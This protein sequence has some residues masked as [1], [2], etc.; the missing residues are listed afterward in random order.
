MA[1]RSHRSGV[2]SVTQ[3]KVLNPAVSASPT[4]CYADYSRTVGHSEVIDIF[5][6]LGQQNL[7]SGVFGVF[8]PMQTAVGQSPD[9]AH[10]DFRVRQVRCTIASTD[11]SLCGF[12]KQA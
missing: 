3:R 11:R 1:P 4:I 12:D 5:F 9:R 7:E 10:Q 6:I 8:K 2:F